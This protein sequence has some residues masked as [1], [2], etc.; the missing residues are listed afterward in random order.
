MG[1]DELSQY[2]DSLQREDC[3]RI[4]AVLKESPHETTQRV[5]FVGANGSRQGP[6]IRKLIKR[7]AHMGAVYE[8]IFKAQQHGR[9]FLHIPRILECYSRDDCLVV[10]M[11]YVEGNTLQET[12][13]RTGPSVELANGVFPQLCDAASELHEGFS[14]AI[15]HRD[16]KPSNI[17][18]SNGNVTLLDFGIARVYC[19]GAASDTV[20]FGTRS[21]APPEQF[22]FG[23]T[24]I[25][26]DVYA[27]GM[28]LYYCLTGST[29]DPQVRERSLASSGISPALQNV[30][31][32]AT[33]FDPA[34][35]YRSA[36]KLK[37]AFLAAL[38]PAMGQFSPQAQ[39]M[40]QAPPMSQAPPLPQQ[41]RP[42]PN[43]LSRKIGL[44]WNVLLVVCFV[45]LL[46]SSVYSITRPAESIAS[47]PFPYIVGTYV[48]IMPLFIAGFFLMICDKRPLKER[49]A[50]FSGF[51]W[52]HWI[53][54]FVFTFLV[55]AIYIGISTVYTPGT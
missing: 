46:I 10:V 32:T 5:F 8:S 11:E 18:I 51:K 2:L 21:F 6:F 24:T 40:P 43:D 55:A 41:A 45:I 7:D 42:Q 44:V 37:S 23:Q 54:L 26:S 35:R 53:L 29:L 19:E 52:W 15:I 27:L 9:R 4:D 3:Y 25:Q 1:N 34:N 13:E 30:I 50:F 12:V 16:L 31:A 22:G 28:L 47:M 17:M 38:F 20:H 49:F 33:A 36:Q 48:I 39:P 14:P